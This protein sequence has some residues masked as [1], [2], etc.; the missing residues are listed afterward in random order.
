MLKPKTCNICGSYG[1][2]DGHHFD[3]SKPLAVLWACRACHKALHFMDQ[4]G[5]TP[6]D[7]EKIV[8]QINETRLNEIKALHEY[9]KS[10]TS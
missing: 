1:P 6:Q 5:E 9:R 2:V 4:W 8:S 10:N 7:I 3:Y